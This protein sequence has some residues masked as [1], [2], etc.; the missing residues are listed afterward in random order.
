[1]RTS[2]VILLVVAVVFG[3]PVSADAYIGP[4]AGF[5]VLSSFLVVFTTIVVAIA[6]I[7]TWPFRALWRLLTGQRRPRASIRRLR[8]TSSGPRR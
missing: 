5:A 2:L 6:A 4:G 1:M 8:T 3:T 7:L